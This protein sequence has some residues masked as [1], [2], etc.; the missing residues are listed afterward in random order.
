M[1]NFLKKKKKEA[2]YNFRSIG[3]DMHSHILPGIDDGA[4]TLTESVLLIKRLKDLGFQQLIAT[5]HVMSDYY[6]N[7]P[8]TIRKAL[9]EVREELEKQQINISVDAA[10]EYY[11]DEF[12]EGKLNQKDLLTFGGNHL[13]FE[14]S[15]AHHP[16]GLQEII[17]KMNGSG[18]KPILAHPERYPY[19]HQSIEKYRTIKEYG[20]YFQLN[21]ISLSGY[22]GKQVQKIAEKLVD[23]ELVDF[24]GSD[25]HHLR[26]ADA[27]ENSL[28]SPY[29][30]KLI[31]AGNLHNLALDNAH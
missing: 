25:M 30:E 8:D 2:K 24:I 21:T 10:A 15:F 26:H 5:P 4:P 16:S 6:R 22:Y 31:E 14:L 11:I 7:T 1:F 12:F 27:L 13:L 19:L 17:Q 9:N 18:Y 3:V 20:C 23:E 29:T 28:I